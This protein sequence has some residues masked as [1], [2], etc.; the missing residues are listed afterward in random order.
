MTQTNQNSLI[1]SMAIIMGAFIFLMFGPIIMKQG[2]F[3]LSNEYKV[4]L[5]FS[6]G[7]MFILFIFVFLAIKQRRNIYG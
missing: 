1:I 5:V 3:N 4:I 6:L 2:L 7:F